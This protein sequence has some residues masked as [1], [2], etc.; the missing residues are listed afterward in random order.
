[1]TTPHRPIGRPRR[2]SEVASS[3]LT[4][5]LEPAD[6]QRLQAEADAAGEKAATTAQRGLL[7]WLAGQAKAD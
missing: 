6:R 2:G 7:E 1:M 3:R 5:R 4:I